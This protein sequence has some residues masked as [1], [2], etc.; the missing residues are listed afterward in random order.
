MS[1]T[2]C[3]ASRRSNSCGSAQRC[4]HL[5]AQ[6]RPH[7]GGRC[8]ARRSGRDARTAVRRERRRPRC[9]SDVLSMIERGVEARLDAGYAPSLVA[10]INATG[11][12]IHTNLGRAPLAPNRSGDAWPTWPPATPTSNTTSRAGPRPA[13]QCTRNACSAALTGAEAAVV[14]NN[15]AAA[16]LLVAGGARHGAGGRHLARRA[17]RNRRRVP[18][19]GRDGAVGRAPARGR[20]DQPDPRLGLCRSHLRSH[21]ADPARPSV[22]FHDRGLHRAAPRST[23]LVALGRRFDIPVVEDLGSGFLGVP[24]AVAALRDEPSV[25]DSL[26][27]GVSLVMFSGDKLLG[28]PQAGIIAGAAERGGAR[29]STSADARAQGRQADLRRPRSH[30][31]GTRGRPR[32]RLDSRRA[33]DRPFVGRDRP[34]GRKRWPAGSPPRASAPNVVDGFFDD[35][36]RQR[37][38]NAAADAARGHRHFRPP[39]SSP[40]SGRSARRSSPESKTNASCSTSA[41]YRQNRTSSWLRSITSAA[42]SLFP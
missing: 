33:H 27:A 11:V 20:H 37:A 31:R 7:G 8:A 41:P 12:I 34:R 16:T 10:V 35:R 39:G 22:E 21:G 32:H 1:D 5:E 2:A 25:V 42:S 28:G 38:R 19:A 9:P 36:R 30:P 13:R 26:A 24:T 15:N 29:A 4:A 3:E 18:C 6:L 40:H 23:D 17:R 14:V